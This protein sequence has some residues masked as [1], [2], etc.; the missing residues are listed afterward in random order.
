MEIYQT[1]IHHLF[2]Q[3][4]R[5][6]DINGNGKLS[7]DELRAL[8][9]DMVSEGYTLHSEVSS[10]SQ[11]LGYPHTRTAY[12]PHRPNHTAPRTTTSQREQ[13]Q[14]ETLL[15]ALDTNKDGQISWKEFE[16]GLQGEMRV[17]GYVCLRSQ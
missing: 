8:V 11:S 14:L 2:A 16:D 4:F 17:R 3:L 13:S 10:R 9:A 15:T 5:K 7:A 6:Y 12:S 1:A